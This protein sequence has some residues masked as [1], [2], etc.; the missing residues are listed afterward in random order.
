LDAE[1]QQ[2]S[3]FMPAGDAFDD[4]AKL[5]EGGCRRGEVGWR[6]KLSRDD[7]NEKRTPGTGR[8]SINSFKG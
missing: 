1:R 4:A 3:T 6:H 8:E 7:E 2:R 5:H